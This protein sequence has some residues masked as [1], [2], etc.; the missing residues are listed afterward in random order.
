[1][2]I[3][4]LVQDFCAKKGL[5]SP[6]ALIGSTD[7]T[8]VQI[9]S[10]CHEV[11]EDAALDPWQ[12]TVKRVTFTSVA[13]ESQGDINTLFGTGYRTLKN[14]SLWNDTQLLEI[15]GPVGDVEWNPIVSLGT[16][17]R[18]QYK[19]M[20]SELHILPVLP[21]GDTIAAMVGTEY[22]ITDSGGTPKSRFTVDND[23]V[24]L[25]SNY[26]KKSLEWRWLKEMG[27]PF[28]GTQYEAN[29]MRAGLVNKDAHMP[30]LALDSSRPVAKPGIIIPAGNW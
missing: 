14:Q 18:Y 3:L 28:T 29:W 27:R 17:P 12:M 16:G 26:F 10:L 9:L 25:P 6:S 5:P 2:N 1:M 20:G 7:Q 30:T 22:L 13:T 15:I 21:A 8:F 4:T 19:I 11:I 23:L 24:L